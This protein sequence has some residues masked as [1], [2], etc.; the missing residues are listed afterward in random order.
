MRESFLE[1]ILPMEDVSDIVVETGQ[2]PLVS[3]LREDLPR[4]F[5]G[6]EGPVIF[7]QED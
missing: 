5:G 1:T 4:A 3:E 6:G 7:S 2:A